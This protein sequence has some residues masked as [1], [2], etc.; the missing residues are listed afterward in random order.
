MTSPTSKAVLDH[1][2]TDVLEIDSA[3]IKALSKA[4]IK[5]YRKLVSLEFKDLDTLREDGDITMSC[6]R[7]ITDY[8]SYVIATNPSYTFIMAMTDATWDSVDIPMLRLNQTLSTTAIAAAKPTLTANTV[9][10]GQIET[11]SFLKYVHL[12]LL[13]KEHFLNSMNCCSLKQ[14][15]TTSSFALPT[16]SLLPTQSYRTA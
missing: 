16:I 3:D 11:V 1:L 4:D 8:K 13:D 14:L 15:G 7:D 10:P 6:W 2:L 5:F 9:T 12:L